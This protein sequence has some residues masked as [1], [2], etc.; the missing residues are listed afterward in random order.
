MK[1][2]VNTDVFFLSGNLDMNTVCTI[3]F[4][5]ATLRT[6]EPELGSGS[7]CVASSIIT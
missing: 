7:P 3:G 5:F 2:G 4:N 1:V 6:M